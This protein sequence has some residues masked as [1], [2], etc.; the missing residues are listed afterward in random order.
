MNRSETR[1]GYPLRFYDSVQNRHWGCNRDAAVRPSGR[2]GGDHRCSI[3]DYPMGGGDVDVTPLSL[4]RPTENLAV[5]EC[6]DFRLQT[7]P[8]C[9]RLG[10]TENRGCQFAV[11][12]L[13][14][15]VGLH[16]DSP[17]VPLSGL[18]REGTI[19]AHEACSGVNRNVAASTMRRVC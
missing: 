7:D 16:M 19:V 14:F 17:A 18:C 6:Y 10:A 2:R 15:L 4:R 13:Y 3:L 5:L 12:E 11:C 1:S 9:N 8:A